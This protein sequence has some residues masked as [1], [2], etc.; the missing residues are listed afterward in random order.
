MLCGLEVCGLSLNY[1][2]S[3]KKTTTSRSFDYKTKITGKT[4]AIASRLD[5]KIVVPLKYMGN[6]WRSFDLPLI[7]YKTEL[8]LS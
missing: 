7:S 4:L 2:V 1:R 5:T 6:P 3:N 8:N